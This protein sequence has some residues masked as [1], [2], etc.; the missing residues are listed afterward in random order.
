[1]KIVSEPGPKN[2]HVHAM[3]DGQ[4][5]VIVDWSCA[6]NVGKFVQRYGD[7]LVSLGEHDGASW[8][9][10]FSNG[11]TLMDSCQVR[12]LKPGTVIEI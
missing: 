6:G 2:I 9:N 1:M 10:L 8:P 11:V 4:I 7:A 12:I 3:K 5:A